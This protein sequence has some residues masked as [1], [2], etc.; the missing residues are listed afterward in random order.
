LR[1]WNVRTLNKPGALQCVLIVAEAY[2]IQIL[3]LHEFRWL[4]KGTLKKEN[5]TLFYSGSENKKHENGVGIMIHDSIL[6]QVKIFKAINDRLCYIILK[7]R[8]F[9]MRIICW[10]GPTED[11]QDEKKKKGKEGRAQ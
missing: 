1:S 9:D 10:Y 6:P 2:E 3:A 7:G 5:M 8:I 4:N 11:R